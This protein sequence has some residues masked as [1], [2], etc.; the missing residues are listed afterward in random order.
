M[1][2]LSSIVE[3]Y[4][5][6]G[7]SKMAQIGALNGYWWWLCRVGRNRKCLRRCSSLSAN[8]LRL[9]Y[10]RKV[11]LYMWVRAVSF[12]TGKSIVVD[13]HIVAN[14]DGKGGEW[15]KKC[16][17]QTKLYWKF[18]RNAIRDKSGILGDW[19]KCLIWRF[20]AKSIKG[21]E[22]SFS[23]SRDSIKEISMETASCVSLSSFS[24][25]FLCH[26]MSPYFCRYRATME[27][28][29]ENAHP[30]FL[31]RRVVMNLRYALFF[32]SSSF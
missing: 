29:S 6:Q 17:K 27:G 5:E 16:E 12:P 15:G 1:N 31:S 4:E 7:I 25:L 32:L 10:N 26:L 18:L 30:L 13:I 3:Y 28:K 11:K 9:D 14:D 8:K 19:Y 24:P 23:S 2:S 22:Y 20:I 21:F